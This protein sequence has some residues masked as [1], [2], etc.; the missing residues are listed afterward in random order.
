MLSPSTW[1]FT[2]ICTC[3]LISQCSS[4]NLQPFKHYNLHSARHF[5]TTNQEKQTRQH[6]HEQV[7]NKDNIDN[8]TQTQKR[9]IDNSY[10][11]ILIFGGQHD[12][13]SSIMVLA[14]LGPMNSI[15]KGVNMLGA[16][17]MAR[18]TLSSLGIRHTLSSTSPW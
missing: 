12:S 2:T 3:L 1:S 18:I 7:L 6:H 17:G 5:N 9:S 16:F 15:A 11:Q 13:N 14:M 8:R 4:I 10:I